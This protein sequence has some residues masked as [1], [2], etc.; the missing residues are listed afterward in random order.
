[1]CPCLK[2]EG[3]LEATETALPALKGVLEVLLLAPSELKLP[4]R[5][6]DHIPEEHK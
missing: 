5:F 3:A 2:Q 6:S 4:G 1:M